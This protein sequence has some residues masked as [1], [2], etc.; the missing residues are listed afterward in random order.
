MKTS[1]NSILLKICPTA[2]LISEAFTSIAH[3]DRYML[4]YG[5]GDP[6][7]TFLTFFINYLSPLLTA[8]THPLIISYLSLL[9]QIYL[10]TPNV[11]TRDPI[12]YYF[13]TAET[14]G[15]GF[16]KR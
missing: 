4:S 6:S 7:L 15:R 2:N 8:P 5:L 16:P 12:R 11:S 13:Y 14:F 3:C 9:H 10:S 1:L